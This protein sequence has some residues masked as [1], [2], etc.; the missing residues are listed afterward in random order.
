ML[1]V[2]LLRQFVVDLLVDGGRPEIET[3][4][5]LRLLRLSMYPGHSGNGI[6]VA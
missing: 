5:A 1:G 3:Q 4:K 6:I 2:T